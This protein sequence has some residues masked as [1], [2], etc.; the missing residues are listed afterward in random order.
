MSEQAEGAAAKGRESTGAAGGVAADV[1]KMSGTIASLKSSQGL[2]HFKAAVKAVEAMNRMSDSDSERFMKPPPPPEGDDTFWVDVRM[3]LQMLNSIDTVTSTAQVRIDVITYWTD[4]RLKGWEKGEP[5]PELLWG[6]RLRVKGGEVSEEVDNSFNLVNHATGRCKRSRGY[7]IL[8]DNKMDLREF[9][10][11][12]DDIELLFLTTSDWC[13][14]NN[15]RLG[16]VASGK[17]TYRIRPVQEKREGDWLTMYWPGDLSE[18]DLLGV[19]T[20]IKEL[21][22]TP[23][24]VEN[25]HLFVAFHAARCSAFYFWKVLLPLY[26]LTFLSFT[27]FQFETDNLGDRVETVSSFFMAAFGA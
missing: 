3:N 20:E 24:G 16:S 26:L 10:F 6:P 14:Y 19:S 15:K 7:V 27:T 2:A 22:K 8:L 12:M 1:K 5:L 21:P 9:P 25:T 23:S 11:D 17:K 13:S 4:P 18:F